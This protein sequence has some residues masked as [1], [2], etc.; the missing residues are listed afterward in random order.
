MREKRKHRNT[1]SE[2]TSLKNIMHQIIVTIIHKIHFKVSKR[3]VNQTKAHTET[4]TIFVNGNT[5]VTVR[6][7]IIKKNSY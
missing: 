6:Y 5:F 4:Y 3:N 2:I 7:T 1:Q